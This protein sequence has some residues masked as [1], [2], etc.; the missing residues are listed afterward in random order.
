MQILIL[1]GTRWLGRELAR[2]ALRRGHEVTCL[3]RGEA[4]EVAPGA[5][6]VVGDRSRADA[7][8]ALG[9]AEWDAVIDVTRQPGFARRAAAALAQRARHWTFISS[10]NVYAHHDEPGADETAELMP[11]SNPTSRRPRPTA[12]RSRRSNRPT[13]RRSATGCSSSGPASSAARATPRAAPVTGS[14]ARRATTSR[15]SCPTSWMPR[16]SS[17]TCATSSAGRSTP[18]SAG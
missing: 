12:R 6:L 13:M 16:R 14:R 4:G 17:S 10:G 1:G 5:R 18:S 7:Y 3:A 15:C 11:P 2:D 9:D 8:D